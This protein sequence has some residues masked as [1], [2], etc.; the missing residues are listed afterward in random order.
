MCGIVGFYGNPNNVVETLVNGLK[1]LEYRGYDSAGVATFS[2]QIGQTKLFVQKATGKVIELEKKLGNELSKNLSSN[3]AK[4][5]IAHTR[6]A[7][8]GEPSESN[9]TIHMIIK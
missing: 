3:F 7:T 8:H 5:G 9:A 6:W 4:V 2:N 1:K